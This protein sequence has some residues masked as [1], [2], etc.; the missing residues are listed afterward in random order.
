MLATETTPFAAARPINKVNPHIVIL[1]GGFGGLNFAKSLRG[2]NARV[3]L[4]D[5]QN[6]HLFQPLLYQVATATLSSVEIAKPLRSILSNYDNIICELA[7][8]QAIDLDA[9]TVSLPDRV[10]EYDYLIISLGGV[11]SYF[12]HPEWAEY[13]PGLKSLNDALRIRRE[14][15]FAFEKAEVSN[16]PEEIKR[17]MTVVIVGGGPTGVE[18][19]GATKEL[20]RYVMRHDFRRIDPTKVRVILVEAADRCLLHLP[21]DLS[22]SAQRQLESIGVEIRVNTMVKDIK[23]GRVV[24]SSKEKPDETETINA[25][26]IVWSAGVAANPITRTM[27]VEIDRAGRIKVNPDLSIPGHPE[28]FAIGDIALILKQDG[29]PV[30]GVSPAAIQMGQYVA[31]V[32]KTELSDVNLRPDQRDPF[33]YWDKGTMATIGHSHAVAMIGPFKFSGLP[34]WVMWLGVHILYLVGFT[35]KVMVVF[36]WG[37]AFLT[38]RQSA[39]VITANDGRGVTPITTLPSTTVVSPPRQR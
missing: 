37:W 36:R 25:A 13:A 39:R 19:A 23:H 28:A 17:L 32:I 8:A 35:N 12:G 18:L 10:I 11:T 1:G 33:V 27:D 9:R 26:A 6:H 5:R 24:V 30:P 16:D 29:L 22:R 14:I 7:E 21:R 20:G 4:I 31:K 15:L 2:T 38:R 3:T 34:A